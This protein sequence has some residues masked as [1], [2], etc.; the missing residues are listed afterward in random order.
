VGGRV[1]LYISLMV[2]YT[3]VQG[4]VIMNLQPAAR[5]EMLRSGVSR[6]TERLAP[7]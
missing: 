2:L 6:V 5:Q 4:G 1:T 7:G 3:N